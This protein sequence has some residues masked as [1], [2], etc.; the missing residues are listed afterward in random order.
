M[1]VNL[2]IFKYS[3]SHLSFSSWCLE[4]VK[5]EVRNVPSGSETK[6]DYDSE[7]ESRVPSLLYVEKYMLHPLI[8]NYNEYIKRPINLYIP[9]KS[10]YIV[11]S[12]IF[13]RKSQAA[14]LTAKELVELSLMLL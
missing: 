7:G 1:R 5:S 8:D 14:T 9:F 11:A 3:L 6:N 10:M 4:Q 13:F 2:N 12:R